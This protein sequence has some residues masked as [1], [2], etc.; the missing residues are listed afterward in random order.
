[1][2]INFVVVALKTTKIGGFFGGG[3]LTAI[4]IE[5]KK[6]YAMNVF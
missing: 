5:N 1:M 3:A 6:M 4:C 2:K